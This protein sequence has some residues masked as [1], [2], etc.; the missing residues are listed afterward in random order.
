[1]FERYDVTLQDGN[2]AF[3]AYSLHEMASG[4]HQ[5]NRLILKGRYVLQGMEFGVQYEYNYGTFDPDFGAGFVT[6]LADE[7]IAA[8]HNVAVGSRGFTG[9]FGGWNSL[10]SRDFDQYR[11]KAFVKVQF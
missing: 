5:K 8:E 9:R 11:L 7:K 1:V 2:T 6:Q 3:Q 4:D 10:E